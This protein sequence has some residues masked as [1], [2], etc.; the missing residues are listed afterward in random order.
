VLHNGY[1][2]HR[3]PWAS[4]RR[5]ASDLPARREVAGTSAGVLSCAGAVAFR[6][7]R[8]REREKGRDQMRGLAVKRSTARSRCGEDG[9]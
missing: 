7:D 5:A 6:R 3:L 1:S 2:W 4:R 9:G 8:E